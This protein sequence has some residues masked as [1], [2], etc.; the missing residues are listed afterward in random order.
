[1]SETDVLGGPSAG[2]RA[3][4]GGGLRV[5]GYGAG[6]LLT[7]VTSLLLLR[8][9]SVEDFGVYVTVTSLVAIVAG[10]TEAGLGL[11]AQRDW[12]AAP[13]DGER[14]EIVAAVVGMR[15]VATPVGVLVALG[16]GLAAGY[17]NRLLAGIAIAGVGLVIA[18]VASALTV[19]LVAQLRL[20][21]VTAAD[22][23]RSLA[24][25]GTIA[26]VV[27]AGGSLAAL[28]IAHIAGAIA[29]LAVTAAVLGGA[30]MLRPSFDRTRWR[31]LI[32]AAAPV[33]AATVVNVV[34]LRLLVIL[35]SILADPVET[36][37]FGTSYRI[38]EVF[39]GIPVLMMGAAFPILAHAGA[40][41]EP[42]LA[43][44]LQRMVE[45]GLLIAG[46]AVLVL[47]AAAEPIVLL[48]GDEEYRAAGPVLQIQALAL[49]G[50]FLTQVYA[51]GLVAIHRQRALVTVNVVALATALT[52]GLI[53]IP[54]WDEKGAALAAVLGE[55]TLAATCLTLLVRARPGLRPQ[56]GRPLKLLLA[57]VVAYA[58]GL[59]PGLPD[60]AA[61]AVSAAVFL[62]LAAVLRAIPDELLDAVRRYRGAP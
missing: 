27:V 32:V 52:S 20:G 15:L 3:V 7:A 46:L 48:L 24:I 59:V 8:Y 41:D 1:V 49:V 34:Y 42:R 35:M 50:A 61:A 45:A 33:A 10:L 28:F 4:R 51:L 53:L 62:G 5:A 14:R 17:D 25:M 36:G 11:V 55:L 57:G 19:P 47:V 21:A 37:L 31:T 16:F 43:Y 30:A 56:A 6:A 22:L 38:L 9:L 23:A 12:I 18:N 60:V 58:A 44:A 54:L 13:D 2:R 29:M 39:A 26:I 40:A